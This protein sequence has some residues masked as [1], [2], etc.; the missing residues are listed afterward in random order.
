METIQGET[1]RVA[2]DQPAQ[3][4]SVVQ[5]TTIREMTAREKEIAEVKAHAEELQ[6]SVHGSVIAKERI[7][8]GTAPKVVES[9]DD[10]HFNPSSKL[11]LYSIY[12]E[13][14]GFKKL[15]DG[16]DVAGLIPYKQSRI[17]GGSPCRDQTTGQ[18]VTPPSRSN[19]KKYKCPKCGRVVTVRKVADPAT[20]TGRSF[21]E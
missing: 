14:C 13:P 3:D 10:D 6:K 5:G 17:P 20:Q 9:D 11:K 8:L 7:N 1:I 15:T 12:C 4:D 19:T 21:D 16:S 18:I 2:A